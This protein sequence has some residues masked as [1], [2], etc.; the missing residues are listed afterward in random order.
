MVIVHKVEDFLY[1]LFPR[2]KSASGNID[3]LV[4]ELE[5]YY[6][7]GP[8][9]P[10]I[11][12]QDGWVKVEI[13]TQAIAS[14]E[15]EYRKAIALC[16]KGRFEQAKDIL[17]GLVMKNPT[18]SEY[19]RVLGQV[20][21]EEGNQEEAVNSLIDA[22]RW[23]PENAW[24]LLMMGNIF[25]KHKNDIQTALRYY[26]QAV[27]VNPNDNIAINNIGANLMQQ[28][29]TGEAKKYF[30]KAVEL[31]PNYP[32]THYALS[33]VA[34]IEGDLQSSLYSATQALKKNERR[35]GLYQNTL[36]QITEVS[37]KIVA[38][39][40]GKKL[41]SDYKNTLELE[42][43]INI[44]IVPDDTLPTAA[45]M[46]LAE[47]YDREEHQVKYKPSYPAVDHLVMH[48]LVHIDFILQARKTGE[49]QLFVSTQQQK[50]IFVRA[51]EPDLKRLKK[52]GIGE[53]SLAKYATDL[54]DGI[55]RQ[56]YN[57]PIDLFIEDF[58]YNAYPELRAYQFLSLYNMGREAVHAVTDR[59][60]VELSPKTVL[61]KSKVFNL[62]SAM[63]FN[64]LY[65][66]NMLPD[67]NASQLELN[68]AKAL[69]DEYLEYRNDRE[70]AE[71]YELVANWAEDMK[72]DKYFEL[73]NEEEYR[74]KRTNLDEL[75]TS[76]ERD[77]YGIN[78]KDPSKERDMKTFQQSQ[79]DIGTNMAVIMFMVDAL[80]YF[81]K[82]P[83]S[84]VREI[85]FEIARLGTM[86]IRPDV[87]DYTLHLIRGKTFSGYHLLA[88][89]YVSWKLALPEMIDRL[90]LPYDKEYSM[91]LTMHKP[92]QN[93]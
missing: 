47:N 23:N 57:T 12:V 56:I 26:D 27:K 67:F 42:G 1:E 71:E 60:I 4:K 58:L 70:P 73:V 14:E 18:N 45:K 41:I 6:T 74:G 8:Y 50:A 31:N 64:E 65:G 84:K 29:K 15:P 49:N 79:K 85:A 86:G 80:Q 77:P 7:Y 82:M 52:M 40:I 89:Y 24:A 66:V 17:L 16:E 22:L 10:R 48:E 33:L 90:Q 51:L 2:A 11:S 34:E 81:E 9:K 76:I 28:G 30:W 92:T 43:E 25:A 83:L 13:D 32:N 37:K 59:K 19:H 44:V 68:E 36:R 35:D 91:A 87:K 55:N 93:E 69:Y 88:Y 38:T 20:L 3:V 72:L 46:E 63:H 54:F 62:V 75:L 53:E 21:S 5:E 39:G 78:V 61:S